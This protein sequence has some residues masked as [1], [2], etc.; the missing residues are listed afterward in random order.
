MLPTSS[1]MEA[2]VQMLSSVDTVVMGAL[3]NTYKIAEVLDYNFE[4][5]A[6]KFKH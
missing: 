5:V 4:K 1:D 3:N 2:V 6:K